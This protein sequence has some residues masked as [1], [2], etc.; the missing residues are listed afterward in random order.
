DLR[1]VHVAGVAQATSGEAL[2]A[3][4]IAF[5]PAETVNAA[6]QELA[7]GHVD[8]VVYDAAILQY[9][10]GNEFRERL[11]VL[12]LRFEPQ[13]LAFALP[14]DSPLREPFDRKILEIVNGDAWA[15]ILA[16]YLGPR[17]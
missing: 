14:E 7:A 4:H 9:L 3:R 6:M 13:E 8:A 2:T 5:T 1:G 12:P 17:H 16:R 15:G 11:E 10:A